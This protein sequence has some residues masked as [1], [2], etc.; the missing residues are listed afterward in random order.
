VTSAAAVGSVDLGDTTS[1]IPLFKN[2]DTGDVLSL[3][4]LN[5]L[6]DDISTDPSIAYAYAA[7]SMPAGIPARAPA[8][9]QIATGPSPQIAISP[10]RYLTGALRH[11]AASAAAK[12][13]AAAEGVSRRA[14]IRTLNDQEQDPS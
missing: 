1:R 4:T 13:A 12:A 8:A 6:G 3:D 7:A 9:P 14:S 5:G 10:R 11:V 2:L